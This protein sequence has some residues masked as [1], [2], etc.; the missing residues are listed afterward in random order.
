MIA[1]YGIQSIICLMSSTEVGF[2]QNLEPGVT[3]LLSYYE[4]RFKVRHLPWEDPAHSKSPQS[5]IEMKKREIRQ[6]ALEAFDDLPKP[7]LLHCSAGIQR[8]APVA[9]Y[10]WWHRERGRAS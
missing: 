7:I 2:Y 8:S 3:D 9:A 6:A 5:V 1:V 10:I 4:S